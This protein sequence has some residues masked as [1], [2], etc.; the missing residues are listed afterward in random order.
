[1]ALRLDNITEHWM[2]STPTSS[3]DTA[4]SAAARM[5]ATECH[6]CDSEVIDADSDVNMA[7]IRDE[8][9]RKLA[10]MNEV[11]ILARQQQL[12]S[13]LGILYS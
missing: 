6:T 13:A 8:N 1:M 4:V 2:Q 3:S 11:E 5:S 7:E 10:A 12:L 9:E